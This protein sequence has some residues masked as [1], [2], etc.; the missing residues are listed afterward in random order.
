MQRQ[1]QPLRPYRRQQ[2]TPRGG[3]QPVK[4]RPFSLADVFGAYRQSSS[5]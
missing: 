4:K 2:L 3:L 5:T 1:I